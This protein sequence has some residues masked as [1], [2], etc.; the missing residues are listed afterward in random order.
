M[1]PGKNNL[2]IESDMGRQSRRMQTPSLTH[3]GGGSGRH[4]ATGSF[5]ADLGEPAAFSV[6]DVDGDDID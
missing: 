3:G 5:D 4:L 1:R 6:A 2:L